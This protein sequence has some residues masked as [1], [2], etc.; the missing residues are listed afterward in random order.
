M[1]PARYIVTTFYKFTRLSG[2]EVATLQTA[3]RQQATEREILGT[4]ILATEGINGTLAGTQESIDGMVDFLHSYAA[5]SDLKCQYSHSDFMPFH[6]TKILIKPEIVTLGMPSLDPTQQSGIAVEPIAW[7]ALITQPDVLLIDTR[8]DYE[9]TEGT[10]QNAQNPNTPTFRNFPKYVQERL[11]ATKHKKIAMFCTGGVRCEKASAFLLQQNF[12]AVY[13]LQG[14]I[15]NYL[16]KIDP[17]ESLWTGKCFIFDDRT[18][19][20]AQSLR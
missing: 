10:F 11:D 12:E 16:A 14:G 8:N 19:L 1:R 13:Q 2:S 17:T 18:T 15:L 9:I 3:I 6:K 5:F 4:I 20:E 7:N